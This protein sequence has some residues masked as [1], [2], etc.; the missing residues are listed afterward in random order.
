VLRLGFVEPDRAQRVD[1]L[2][3]RGVV[4]RD[5]RGGD[6]DVDNRLGQID[7]EVLAEEVGCHQVGLG[8]PLHEGHEVGVEVGRGDGGAE[9]QLVAHARREVM[10]LDGFDVDRSSGQLLVSGVDPTHVSERD[11]GVAHAPDGDV[12]ERIPDVAEFEI[13]D[14]HEIP[15]DVVEL[16][17]VPHAWRHATVAVR[18]MAVVPPEAEL[19]ERVDVPL[20]L[21]VA[22][23]HVAVADHRRVL[24]RRGMHDPRRDERRRVDRVQAG[25][26]LDVLVDDA[27]AIGFVDT[28]EVRLARHAL[29]QHGVDPAGRLDVP[30]QM[31]HREATLLHQTVE[32]ELVAQ[33]ERLGVGAVTAQHERQRLTVTL[34]RQEPRRPPPQL[35]LDVDDASAGVAL[36]DPCRLA[37][38]GDRRVGHLGSRGRPNARSPSRF[39]MI[40]LLPP[41][42]V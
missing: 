5:A 3:E 41:E 18:E 35:A 8:I 1:Q 10:S 38:G 20:A 6:L 17:G 42:I 34:E 37:G 36:D 4:A 31:R 23:L 9:L 22:P 24:A 16:S 39:C 29:H 13:D 27:I 25:E 32:G 21:A 7:R 33:R 15:V 12:A 26:L 14:R 11:Q 28:L 40:W 2:R 19:G 30:K